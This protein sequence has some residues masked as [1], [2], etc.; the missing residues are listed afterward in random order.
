MRDKSLLLLMAAALT[1]WSTASAVT[2]NTQI[3][4]TSS[5]STSGYNTVGTAF[6]SAS[7]PTLSDGKTIITLLDIGA[8][9]GGFLMFRV[10][11]FTADPGQNYFTNII[12]SCAFVGGTF[13]S[14]SSNYLF[15]SNSGIGQWIWLLPPNP[16]AY[17]SCIV[18]PL[19]NPYSLS[20]N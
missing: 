8:P 14:A 4:A 20:V 13:S 3:T 18:G 2:G 12:V 17:N 5:G 19:G 10:S 7:N 15:D 1:W 11:G 6:G 9:G 16:W